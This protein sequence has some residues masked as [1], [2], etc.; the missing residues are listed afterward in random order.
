MWVLPLTRV[1]V[2][3]PLLKYKLQGGQQVKY[4]QGG[5]DKIFCPIGSLPQLWS[6]PNPLNEEEEEG[7]RE[8]LKILHK[9]QDKWHCQRSADNAT[10][11][12]MPS[13]RNLVEN[14]LKLLQGLAVCPS[15]KKFV[16][17]NYGIELLAKILNRTNDERIGSHATK[18]MWN[19][20][21]SAKAIKDSDTL[22][23]ILI[24]CSST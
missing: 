10:Y 7:T 16:N 12:S 23:M 11:A 22:A 6:L 8:V 19:L 5:T 14:A 4:G 13:M 24:K 1:F 3:F 21:D 20:S 17:D 2:I 18:A 9:S 15:N